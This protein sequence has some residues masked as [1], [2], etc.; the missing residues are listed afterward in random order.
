MTS[1]IPIK[2]AL[3]NLGGSVDVDEIYQYIESNSNDLETYELDSSKV[4][5]AAIDYI[6]IL[7]AAGSVASLAS[8]LWM[9]YEK[10]IL[11]KK[12]DNET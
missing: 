6:A 11:P 9:A 3:A 5:A 1:P 7:N 4:T 12:Q 10:Y 2:I 8:L